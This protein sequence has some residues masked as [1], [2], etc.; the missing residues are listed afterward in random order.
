M[1]LVRFANLGGR[2]TIRDLYQKAPCRVMFPAPQAGDPKTAVLLTTSGGLTGGDRLK[3]DVEVEAGAS[4]VVV[5]QAAEKIYR[6]LGND[7]RIDVSLAVGAGAEAE[8]LMQETILFDG[9]RLWRST[10][11][12]VAVDGKLLAVE[13][14]VFGRRSMREDFG[15]GAL[16]DRWR[17]TRGG[18]LVWVDALRLEGDVANERVRQ[19][20]FGDAAGCATILY[21]GPDAATYLDLVRTRLPE[22]SGGATVIDGVLVIRMLARHAAELRATVADVVTT[23]RAAAFGRPAAMPR[24]WS[25]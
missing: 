7:C 1:A 8:W 22:R 21:V 19:F 18:R 15:R 5:T 23:L 14:V 25:V 17:I 24:V 20:G 13:S 10:A 11:A 6:S 9:A 3:I 4:C 16:R 12:D 2:T